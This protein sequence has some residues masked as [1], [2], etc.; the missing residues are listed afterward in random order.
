ME[1]GRERDGG[2]EREGERE[3]I[4]VHVWASWHSLCCPKPRPLTT[5]SHPLTTQSHPLMTKP[6]PHLQVSTTLLLLLLHLG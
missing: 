3:G 2:R 5:Q 1:G 6:H 4:A